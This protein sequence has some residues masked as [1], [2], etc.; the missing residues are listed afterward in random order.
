MTSAARV[1]WVEWLDAE[2]LAPVGSV[3][4]KSHHLARLHS[5]GFRVP[6][7]FTVTTDAFRSSIARHRLDQRLSELFDETID[8]GDAE[9]IARSAR[10]RSELLDNGLDPKLEHELRAAYAVLAERSGLLDPP[11]AVRSSATTED[12][13]GAS[14]AGQ[15]DTALWVRGADDL[16]NTVVRCWASLYTD[17]AVLYRRDHGL[18]TGTPAMAVLV[19]Q[20]VIPAAAGVAFSIDPVTGARDVVLI[21]AAFGLGEAVVSGI[22][23]PDHFVVD[24]PSGRVRSRRIST[25]ECECVVADDRVGRRELEP[26]RASLPS[27]RDDEAV[28]VAELAIAAERFFGAPQ[29]IEWA[30]CRSPGRSPELWILQSRPETVQ[31]GSAG[32]TVPRGVTEPVAIAAPPVAPRHLPATRA[33]GVDGIVESLMRREEAEAPS[34]RRLPQ[35]GAVGTPPGADGWADMYPRSLILRAEDGD[36][37]WFRDASHW[38]RPLAPFEATVL[39][40]AMTSLSQYNTRHFLMPGALGIEHRVLHGY[41]YLSTIAVD[42]EDEIDRRA[43]EFRA[44]AG[45]YFSHWDELY[46]RWMGQAREVIGRLESITWPALP[47][48]VPLET[49]LAGTGIG[50]PHELMTAYHRLI[51]GCLELW[52]LHFEF[53][54]LGYAA[55][56][57]FFEFCRAAV[58]GTTEL[59]IARMVTGIEV[60][61]YRPDREMRRLAVLAVQTGVAGI[62]QIPVTDA[63]VPSLDGPVADWWLSVRSGA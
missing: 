7:G 50:T 31:S 35:I 62:R 46:E 47:A 60:D 19:Q 44:R 32:P 6:D 45:H 10:A 18:G 22:V 8:L 14:G 38:P 28:T 9:L 40:F 54:N 1:S 53:L 27:L 39:Q 42:D 26:T 36:R 21:D 55:Y 25:K 52:Q 51:E 56:L 11:V 49:V 63:L 20:M 34:A 2:M 43:E 23:T 41:P 37:F 57:D 3:G 48:A 59:D 4:A 16:V 15:Q 58:T 24:K 5:A 29:D 61:L 33:P 12:L 13:T 17:R 30:L